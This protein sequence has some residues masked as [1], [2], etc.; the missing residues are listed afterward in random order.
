MIAGEEGKLRNKQNTNGH[1][2][3]EKKRLNEGC[4][5]L[6]KTHAHSPSLT[7]THARTHPHSLA[8]LTTKSKRTQTSKKIWV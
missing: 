7:R 8:Q 4:M 5:L 6:L 3:I 1:D 2:K